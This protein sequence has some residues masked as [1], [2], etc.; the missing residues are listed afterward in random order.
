MQIQVNKKFTRKNSSVAAA[1]INPIP[2][3]RRKRMEV[4]RIEKLMII[5]KRWK[6]S[7][8]SKSTNK[9]GKILL[10]KLRI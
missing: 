3:M 7:R 9:S 2:M 1:D 4:T 6:Q 10:K 5:S 8:K